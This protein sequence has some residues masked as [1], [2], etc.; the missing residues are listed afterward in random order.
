[1]PLIL[2]Y[3]RA[4]LDQIKLENSSEMIKIINRLLET[5]L[6]KIQPK[7]MIEILLKLLRESMDHLECV[8]FNQYLIKTIGKIFKNEEAKK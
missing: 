1:M 3:F 6:N 4:D 5:L 2:L 7:L 8:K